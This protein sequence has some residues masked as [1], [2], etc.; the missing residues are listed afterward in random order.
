MYF[1]SLNKY[2]PKC[3]GHNAGDFHALKGDSEEV[4]LFSLHWVGGGVFVGAWS[5]ALGQSWGNDHL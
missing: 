1:Y 5:E 3:R 2:S 4:L